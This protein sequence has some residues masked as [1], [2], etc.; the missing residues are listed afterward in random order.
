MH[1]LWLSMIQWFSELSDAA[2]SRIDGCIFNCLGFVG[3]GFVSLNFLFCRKMLNLFVL[4]SLCSLYAWFVISP[5]I[6]LFS[7]GWTI[8]GDLI[9]DFVSAKSRQKISYIITC[10]YWDEKRIFIYMGQITKP[11]FLLLGGRMSETFSFP[12]LCLFRFMSENCY[13]SL[14]RNNRA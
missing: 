12:A 10:I 8:S 13:R 5:N 6:A 11:S 1:L 14:H 9:E 4:A 2:E 7:S 3:V